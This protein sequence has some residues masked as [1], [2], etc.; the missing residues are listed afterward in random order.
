MSILNLFFKKKNSTKVDVQVLPTEAYQKAIK[1]NQILLVD[2][3]TPGEYRQGHIAKAIN[4]NI[5]NRGA[6]K[7]HFEKIA[8]NTPVYLYCRSGQRSQQAARLLAKMGFTQLF[9]LRGGY[10]AWQRDIQ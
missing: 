4:L 2:V 9:D 7:S 5:F 10:I 1:D 3:R 6:F 8:R